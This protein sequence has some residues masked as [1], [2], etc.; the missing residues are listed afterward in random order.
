MPHRYPDRNPGRRI[1]AERM[2]ARVPA[3]LRRARPAQNGLRT[4]TDGQ[5]MATGINDERRHPMNKQLLFTFPGRG[6]RIPGVLHELD[7]QGEHRA[8]LDQ[9]SDILGEDV[10]TLD[11]PQALERTRAVQLCIL[12]AGVASASSAHRA[13]SR[14]RLRLRTVH[15]RVS[16][17]GRLRRAGFRRC[18]AACLPARRTDGKSRADRIRI[19]RHRR[20]AGT[21][22][23]DARRC[24]LH[25]GVPRTI[26]PT[27]THP[28]SSSSPVP[29]KP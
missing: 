17:G 2:A 11:T 26:S 6:A 8:L 21:D 29:A 7:R 28:T 14:S 18:L 12:I 15:R 22:G 13:K 25:T 24:R 4:G 23:A 9:A 16:G 1:R 5:S 20:V 27:S 10:M 3:R 19:V